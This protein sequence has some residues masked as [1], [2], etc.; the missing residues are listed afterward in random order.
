MVYHLGVDQGT[1]NT[2]VVLYNGRKIICTFTKKIPINF[3]KEGWVEQNANL[4]IEN[5]IF[6]IKQIIT[7]SKIN[8]NKIN[9]IG[10]ANQ[11][12]TFVVWD[13][14]SGKPIIPAIS[15]QCK[16]SSK[17]LIKYKNNFNLKEINRK[18]G[19]NLD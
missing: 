13:K 17:L 2:K 14:K 18:T 7:I 12:E 15:W 16:R 1:T 10:I 9:T 6:C 11:T 8:I 5:I 4:M 19:L 3:T